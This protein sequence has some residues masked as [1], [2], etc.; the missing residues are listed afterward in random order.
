[1]PMGASASTVSSPPRRRWISRMALQEQITGYLYILPAI[2]LISVFGLFPIGYAFYMSLRR[3]RVVDRGFIGFENYM[4][5]LGDPLGA[6]LFAA[7]FGLLVVAYVVWAR[8][9]EGRVHRS[10]AGKLGPLVIVVVSLFV[11]SSGWT[12]MAAEGDDRFLNSIPVTFYYAMGSIPLQLAIALVLAYI[13]FQKIRGQELFRMIFFLPYVTPVIATALVFRNIFSPRDTSI[14]NRFLTWIGMDPQK[15]LFEPRPFIEVVFGW[16]VEG[17]FAG[18]SMALVSII[19]FGIWTFVGYNTVI[20][21]AGLGNIPTEVYEAA[22]IDG[23]NQWQL[24]RHITIPLLSPVT[25]YL[26][27]IGFIGT[28]KAFNHIFVMQEPSA[29]DTVITT[30]VSI[31]NTFYKASQFGYASAQAI[32]LLGI[33][34]FLTYVQTKVFGE[35]VFYG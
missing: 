9:G 10:L 30:S 31:F 34:L 25:F 26:S 18:P 11:I 20:F 16:H 13:L 2:L 14:A 12:R 27:L 19:A 23:A 7:G 33:I 4:K 8:A 6:L 3:W 1:M 17:F 5:A 29:R 24:F 21:L 15:W 28:F 32:L 35:R 22:E